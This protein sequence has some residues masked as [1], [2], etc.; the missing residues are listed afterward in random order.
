LSGGRPAEALRLQAAETQELR[1]EVLA[2][3]ADES[4]PWTEAAR[5]LGEHQEELPQALGMLLTWY[6][7][8]MLLASGAPAEL[9][10][11]VDRRTELAAALAGETT[12]SLERKCQAILTATDQLERNQ[13][14]QLVLEVMFMQL[15]K[16][17]PVSASP[18][19]AAGIEV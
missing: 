3:V 6:R 18:D 15:L 2:L 11:N 4:G 14:A 7:D 13:N 16:K 5:R 1:A 8:L 19:R 10:L 12:A 9:L 17:I